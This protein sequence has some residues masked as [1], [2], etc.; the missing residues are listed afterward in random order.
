MES[1][2]EIRETLRTVFRSMN[3]DAQEPQEH[4][5]LFHL[6]E[7]AEDLAGFSDLCRNPGAYTPDQSKKIVVAVLY[8]AVGHLA[9]AARLYD[10]F[11]DPFGESAERSG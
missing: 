4:D 8:H 9:Q 5:F 2:E 1:S 10:Y 6:L 3:E 7:S 11:P